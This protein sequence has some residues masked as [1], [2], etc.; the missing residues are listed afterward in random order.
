MGLQR[1]TLK[2]NDVGSANFK[3]IKVNVEELNSDFQKVF[4]IAMIEAM[5]ND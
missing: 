2:S 5:K 1:K 4:K 3:T